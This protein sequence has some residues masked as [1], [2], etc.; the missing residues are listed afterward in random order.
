M[1]LCLR[2]RVSVFLFVCLVCVVGCL[3]VCVCLC[4]RVRLVSLSFSLYIVMRVP[5]QFSFVC[6]AITNMQVHR[7]VWEHQHHNKA[8]YMVPCLVRRLQQPST[9]ARFHVTVLPSKRLNQK[10][11]RENRFAVLLGSLGNGAN[12]WTL[13]LSKKQGIHSIILRGNTFFREFDEGAGEH[14]S[15]ISMKVEVLRLPGRQ[16]LRSLR[17]RRVPPEMPQVAA[18][19]ALRELAAK[20]FSQEMIAKCVQNFLQ[21]GSRLGPG[22]CPCTNL[23]GTSPLEDL[24]DAEECKPGGATSDPV[25][26]LLRS[27]LVFI[28]WI[29]EF[30][31]GGAEER[32]EIPLCGLKMDMQKMDEVEPRAFAS[33]R[34][35]DFLLL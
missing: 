30:N 25:P 4:L 15:P 18:A 17:C 33:E 10:C 21:G 34:P 32:K 5:L 26:L 19:E 3:C 24:E 20:R 11:Q 16:F 27:V 23:V 29:S 28:A 6:P 35:S 8:I 14:V 13:K 1:C 7:R 9:F 22:R 2:M 12:T 31:G